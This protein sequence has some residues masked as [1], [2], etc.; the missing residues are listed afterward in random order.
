LLIKDKL[1]NF[2]KNGI[3]N[4]EDINKNNLDRY[5]GIIEKQ[6]SNIIDFIDRETILVIDELE[7]CKKFANNWYLDSDSNFNFCTYEINENLKNNDINLEAKPNLHLKFEEILNSLGNFNLIKFYEFESKVN[8]D[9]RFTLNDKRLNS[10]S[11]NIGKLSNDI[12]KKLL[13]NL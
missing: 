9:N 10:Y 2:S 6:P 3:F 5:L 1:N 7:D 4:S 13:I 11:K 12:N 8:I